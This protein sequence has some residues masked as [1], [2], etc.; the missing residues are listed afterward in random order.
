[1]IVLGLDISMTATGW[2]IANVSG[3]KPSLLRCGVI[4]TK[5]SKGKGSGTLDSIRRA[6]HIYVELGKVLSSEL[7]LK[8]DLICLESMSWPR[9]AS[10]SIKMAIAWGA[11]A[12]LL[13]DRPL[14]P[15]GP[16]ALKLAVSGKKTAS[17]AEVA[18]G[19]RSLMPKA[20]SR[21]LKEFVPKASLQEHC[22]D[23]LG[24]ILASMKTEKFQL[25]KAGLSERK[26]API[27]PPEELRVSGEPPA[28][29]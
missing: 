2:A 16:M 20:T 8:I 10:S 22:W 24:A 27:S 25:L 7:G 6:H 17:K 11:I 15:V 29:P 12:P 19:V 23:A 28:Y 26:T 3:Q 18:S 1:M 5:K 9:N 21:V 13:A 4:E 14:I